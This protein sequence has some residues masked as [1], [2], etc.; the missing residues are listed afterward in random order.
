MIEP[1]AELFATLKELDVAVYQV[2]P[3]V[4][5]TFPC[6]TFRVEE[7]TPEYELEPEIGVQRIGVLIDIYAKTSIESGELLIELE[8][9]LRA[10]GYRLMNTFDLQEENG[11]SHVVTVF[12]IIK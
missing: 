12:N 7:N 9:L 10:E 5:E 11:I 6:I 8:E 4:L 3:E 1:K 2:R